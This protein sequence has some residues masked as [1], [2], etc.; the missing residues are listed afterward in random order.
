[1]HLF[2]FRLFIAQI[3]LF[4]NYSELCA[5]YE[6]QEIKII[7]LILNYLKYIAMEHRYSEIDSYILSQDRSVSVRAKCAIISNSHYLSIK[8]RIIYH[9]KDYL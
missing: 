4:Q 5:L 1:M 9:R 2:L 6:R 8:H 3:Y 7:Y